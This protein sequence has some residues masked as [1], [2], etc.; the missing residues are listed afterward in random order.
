MHLSTVSRPGNEKVH[1][2][3]GDEKQC[4][5]ALKWASLLIPPQM[6]LVL[7]HIHRP[8]IPSKSI[9]FVGLFLSQHICI[10]LDFDSY[11]SQVVMLLVDGTVTWCIIYRYLL[12]LTFCSNFISAVLGA[13]MPAS[14]LIEDRVS[15]H[16]VNARNMI[17]KKLQEC[18][19]MYKVS[20]ETE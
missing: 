2:A 16:S 6:S 1:L 17:R 10:P 9:H 3:V 12:S 18:L 20:T 11:E 19:Q 5:I 7:V 13:S 14:T 15:A 4:L 8:A